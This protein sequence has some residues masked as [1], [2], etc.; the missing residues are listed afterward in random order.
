[1]RPNAP[2]VDLRT[3]FLRFLPKLWPVRGL[4]VACV[5]IALTAPVLTGLLLWLVKLG[6]DEVM[7]GHR[8]DLLGSFMVLYLILAAGKLL[9]DYAHERLEAAILEWVIQNIRTDL[10]R[11][12]VCLSPGSIADIRAGDLLSRLSGDAERAEYLIFSGPFAL[13]ADAVSAVF[14][15]CFL[16]V[17]SWKL[18][19]AAFLALPLLLVA[20]FWLAPKLRRAAH[21][22]RV[23]AAAW[24]SLAEERLAA[25]PV[26]RAFCAEQRESQL[27]GETSARARRAELR[28]VAIQATLT[29]LIEL[30]AVVGGLIVIAIGAREIQNGTLTIG[31]IVAFLGSIGSLYGPVMGL[32]KISSRIQRSAAAGQRVIDVLDTPSLVTEKPSAVPLTLKKGAVEFHAVSFAY[33][34]G[35][36]VLRHISL[37]IEPGSTVALVGPSGSGK[38]TLINL[39]LRFHDPSSGSVRIDG[40]DLREVTRQS[41][42]RVVSPVFQD[43]FIVQGSVADNVRFGFPDASQLQLEVATRLAHADGFISD[44]QGRFLARVGPRGTRLSGG[45]RQRLALARALLREPPILLLDEATAAIDSETE[46]LIQDSL[47]RLSGTRTIIL[48]AHRL[49]TVRRADRIVLLQDGVITEDGTPATLLKGDTRCAQLFEAQMASSRV[50]EKAV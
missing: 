46:E 35:P 42:S 38:S 49:S 25:L 20:S 36:E 28:A 30:V 3:L 26:I 4:V 37:N 18:T 27:F 31:T 19:A 2:S 15:F 39:L 32:A 43:A 29:A 41:L 14:Y 1:M 48:V 6:I 34:G 45:Q 11:H 44:M 7:I 13:F 40:T 16:V 12:I 17:L 22:S 47:A 5:A 8:M 9:I 10:Y 23:R 50:R 21:A 33:P 24:L